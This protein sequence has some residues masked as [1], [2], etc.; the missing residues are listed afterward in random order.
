[1][2]VSWAD[3]KELFEEGDILLFRAKSTIFSLSYWIALYGRSSYSHVSIVS[4]SDGE[5]ECLEFKEFRGARKHFLY[6][7]IQQGYNI[8]VYR[9]R[10]L[11]SDTQINTETREVTTTTK[12]FNSEIAKSITDTAKRIIDKKLGYSYGIIWQIIKLYIPFYRLFVF[13]DLLDRL[14]ENSF[15]CSTFVSYL[16][17]SYYIDLVNGI[18]DLYTTPGDISRSGL[19]Q[20]VFSI[21]AEKK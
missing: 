8:D 12:E 19:I 4:L 16:F 5:P 20:Y 7:D 2:T 14:N 10:R 18:S 1:M 17:R 9:I 13:R 6:E 3:A 21:E 11:V 15:V